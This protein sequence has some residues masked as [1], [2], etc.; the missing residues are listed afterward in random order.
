MLEVKNLNLNYKID[1][2]VYKP[3]L[4]NIN[5][6]FPNEGLIFIIGKS[7]SGKSSLLS[8]LEGINKPNQ[9]KIM[10]DNKNLY[11]KINLN[12]YYSNIGILYQD[13]NLFNNLKVIDNLKLINNDIN[14]IEKY[15]K[16]YN[17]E[18][19]RNNYVYKLSGGEKQRVALIR[20]LIKNPDIIFADEPTGALD[21]VSSNFLFEELFNLSK[22]KL[23]IVVTHNEDCIKK[24]NS[25]Y[26]KLENGSIVFNNVDNKV[27]NKSTFNN[28]NIFLNKKILFKKINKENK[29]ISYL[30]IISLLISFLILLLSGNFIYSFN[31]YSNNII[32]KYYS[33]N[34]FTCS[35]INKIKSNN[36][37][38]IT[39]KQIPDEDILDLLN[40]NN[41]DFTMKYNLNYFIS[42]NESFI[43]NNSYDNLNYKP[44]YDDKNINNGIVINSLMAEKY[45]LKVN[46]IIDVKIKR[47]FN[48]YFEEIKD[49]FKE[50]I[51]LEITF[52]INEIINEF[53]FS[54][55]P[56][57]YYN[58]SFLYNLLSNTISPNLS[59]L[60]EKEVNLIDLYNFS[61]KNEELNSY[62]K[63]IIS[64][65][66]KEITSKNFQ[67]ILKNN[68]YEISNDAYV[69]SSSFISLISTL[70]IG[71]DLFVFIVFFGSILI[72]LFINISLI[73][74]SKKDVAIF[75]SLGFKK[76]NIIN[77]YF[78]KD[79]LLISFSFILTC[80]LN[81]FIYEILNKKISNR[82]KLDF[83]LTNNLY[84][85][86][87]IYLMFILIIYFV[88]SIAFKKI[89]NV[90]IYK[91]LKE[92]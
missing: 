10:L 89:Q 4:K 39:K 38:S 22:N 3:I 28:K 81:H 2:N 11:E 14:L 34:V 23:V 15:L 12:E 63:I 85:S 69:L 64:N 25:K 55:S 67:D 8:V 56:K 87:I 71:I 80:F 21:D 16:N 17:L 33:N 13:F 42:N 51:N 47:Y 86:L 7:G 54:N 52:K 6:T 68:N 29:K 78:Y 36:S 62:S 60:K 41:I 58:Y 88:Y 72:L 83:I 45:D 46:S 40:E 31:N 30:S 18:N 79:L 48:F 35:K 91:E 84:F 9:G 57:I 76:R 1:E 90:S 49:Y 32:N 37:L 50:E 70:E 74:S 66:I 61:N 73:N 59:L 26:I 44:Y 19:V 92:E 43:N 27:E 77:S 20:A 65:N 53:N 5:V 24:Y 82:L 75:L